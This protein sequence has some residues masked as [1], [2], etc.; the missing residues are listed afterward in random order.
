MPFATYVRRRLLDYKG[1]FQR[2]SDNT[3]CA[4]E[5]WFRKKLSGAGQVF[6]SAAE[7]R[8]REAVRRTAFATQGK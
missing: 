3:F 6:A 8:G 5:S 1:V 2:G 4:F 7:V